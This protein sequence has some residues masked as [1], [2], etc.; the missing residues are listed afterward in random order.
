M[1]ITVKLLCAVRQINTLHGV[2]CYNG[3][4]HRVLVEFMWKF[5]HSYEK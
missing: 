4:L 1:K 2:P 3:A 5:L